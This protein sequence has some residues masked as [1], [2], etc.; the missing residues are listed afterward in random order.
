M[1]AQGLTVSDWL[2][3]KTLPGTGWVSHRGKG[4]SGNLLLERLPKDEWS[5]Q[6]FHETTVAHRVATLHNM[7]AIS[8]MARRHSPAA[9]QLRAEKKAAAAGELSPEAKQGREEHKRAR[10]RD[11]WVTREL[12][13]DE[14]TCAAMGA[15]MACTEGSQAALLLARLEGT[16][17]EEWEVVVE[18]WERWQQQERGRLVA[19]SAEEKRQAEQQDAPGRVFACIDRA[20]EMH[21][22][23]QEAAAAAQEEAEAEAE[24]EA[25]AAKGGSPVAASPRPGPA[26]SGRRVRATTPDSSDTVSAQSSVAAAESPPPPQ[27]QPQPQSRQPAKV[28]LMPTPPTT[29]AKEPGARADPIDIS[30]LKSEGLGGGGSCA[31]PAW[32]AT[33][34]DDPDGCTV[35]ATATATTTARQPPPRPRRLA[36]RAA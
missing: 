9:R 16:P 14:P 15:L 28:P 35:A 24:A 21:S 8:G 29:P 7:Y 17:R 3:R 19:I 10:R 33:R 22:A 4:K 26:R 12:G 13:V 20:L 34:A 18:T 30:K 1:A 25:A 31:S 5:S 2:R 32:L 27:P 36:A 23:R 6:R 11:D